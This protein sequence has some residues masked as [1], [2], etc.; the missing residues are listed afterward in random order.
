MKDIQNIKE[1][2]ISFETAKLLF[3]KTFFITDWF[4]VVSIKPENVPTSLIKEDNIYMPNVAE[5]YPAPTQALVV[6]WLRLKH[7]I[8]IVVSRTKLHYYWYLYS[9]DANHENDNYKTAEEATEE[10]IQYTLKNLI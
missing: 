5:K 7:N 8:D 9:V 2:Y 1:D 10:A 6:K 4:W 3:K